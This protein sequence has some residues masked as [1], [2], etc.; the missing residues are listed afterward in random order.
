MADRAKGDYAIEIAFERGTGQP[1]SVFRALSELIE[2]FQQIDQDLAH[3]VTVEIEASVVLQEVESGS[4]RAWLS[5]VLKSVDDT[6]LKKLDWKE[7]VGTYLLRAK[8]RLITFLDK[9]PTITT[10]AQ[11]AELE[12]ELLQL[13]RETN[14]R[15]IPAY[16][17]IPTRRLLSDLSHVSSSLQILAV[18]QEALL[19]FASGSLALNREFSVP[20]EA[21]DA[22]MTAETMT[23]SAEMILR[24]KKPDYLG[25][26][27]WD[28]RHQ[29]RVILARVADAEWLSRFQHRAVT[30]RPGDSI[31]ATVETSVHYDQYGEVVAIH[32]TVTKVHGEILLPNW[33]QAELYGPAGDA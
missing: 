13:A 26:S 16:Q 12:A 24:V 2:A 5:T 4:V 29:N 8:R 19:V 23:S 14:V 20:E 21:I 3:S 18:K 11:V 10:R 27:M 32:F 25:Q 33:A 17:P 9:N 28:F 31:R 1:A 22:L 30:L 7:I 15:Q 6:A